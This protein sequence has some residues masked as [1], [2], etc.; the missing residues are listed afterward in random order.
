MHSSRFDIAIAGDCL[1]GRMAAA[2]LAKHGKRL[3]ILSTPLCHDLWQHSS[4]FVEKLLAILGGRACF[5]PY[6]PFQVI[7]SQA[8]VTIHP[9]L[10]LAMELAREFGDSSTAVLA[11]LAKLEHTGQRLEELLWEHGGLPAT[12]LTETARWRWL[13]LRRKLSLSS[14]GTPLASQ[15]QNFPEPVDEWLRALFQGLAL[16]PLDSLTVA[17]GALLWAH[18]CRPE[19]IAATELQQLLHKR[20][21]QFHGVEDSLAGLSSLEFRLGQWHGTLQNGNRFQAQELVLGDL[22]YEPGNHGQPLSPRLPSPN[23]HFLT[24][25]LDGSLSPLLERRVIAGGPLP[26]RMVVTATASGST[27]QVGS[28][29]FADELQVHRQ[30]EPILPFARYTLNRQEHDRPDTDPSDS[31]TGPSLFKLP[32]HQGN[33]LWCV[34]ETRLLPHLGVGGA[35]LLAWTLVRHLDPKII[36]HSN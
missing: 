17:D 18:A 25:A 24:S 13:C 33:H 32:L 36:V 1:A 23:R 5:A 26:M 31:A 19:G 7:S 6:A 10:P 20:F 12:G 4:G 34:D 35:A 30:F 27:G 2:L 15:L 14:L 9:E 3:L 22:G 16:R 29:R 28:T 8:R 11:L 21:E